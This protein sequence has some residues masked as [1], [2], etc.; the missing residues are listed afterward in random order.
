VDVEAR[1]IAIE[2]WHN[3][4]HTQNVERFVSSG[5]NTLSPICSECIDAS[6]GRAYIL[7]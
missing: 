6:I 7:R 1:I 2:H 3:N 5:H 4:M